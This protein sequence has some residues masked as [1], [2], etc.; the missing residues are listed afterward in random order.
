MPFNS[1]YARRFR[2][3]DMLFKGTFSASGLFGTRS[4]MRLPSGALGGLG[5]ATRSGFG[6]FSLSVSISHAGTTV[7]GLPR[8]VAMAVT[9]PRSF[10]LYTSS[11]FSSNNDLPAQLIRTT[12][13]IEFCKQGFLVRNS[14]FLAQYRRFVCICL[15]IY[16]YSRIGLSAWKTQELTSNLVCEWQVCIVKE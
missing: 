4:Y 10:L 11:C 14:E 1:S 12:S 15:H 5:N 6:R 13:R 3:G 16:K 9:L 7:L 2:D 8:R